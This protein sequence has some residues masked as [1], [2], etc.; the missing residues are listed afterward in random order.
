VQRKGRIE[1]GHIASSRR[2]ALGSLKIDI[3]KILELSRRLF[4][5][6]EDQRVPVIIEVIADC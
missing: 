5:P 2:Q 3:K 4:V 6:A 1:R